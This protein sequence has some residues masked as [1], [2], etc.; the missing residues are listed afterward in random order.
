FAQGG[1]SE[2]RAEELATFVT[3]AIE[4]GIV[5]SRTYHSGD[6]LRSVADEL[7]WFLQMADSGLE[8]RQ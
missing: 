2:Q 5:L 3:A 6:P 1:F 7:G 4:G 8:A